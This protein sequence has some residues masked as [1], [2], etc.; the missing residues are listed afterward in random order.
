MAGRAAACH[1]GAQRGAERIIHHIQ[2]GHEQQRV[3]R[4]R[5]GARAAAAAAALRAA[6]AT[7]AAPPL[8]AAAARRLWR[9][10]RA[11]EVQRDVVLEQRAVLRIIVLGGFQPA[12]LLP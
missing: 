11:D 5:R 9:L 8:R 10:W 12:L 3:A 1:V 7:A 2:R 4:P 6:A